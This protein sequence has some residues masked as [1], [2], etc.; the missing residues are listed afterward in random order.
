MKNC[1]PSLVGYLILRAQI[2]S[3]DA[4]EYEWRQRSAMNDIPCNTPHNRLRNHDEF[5]ELVIDVQPLTTQP[6]EK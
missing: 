2:L 3:Y 4:N 5:I 6:R 1:H